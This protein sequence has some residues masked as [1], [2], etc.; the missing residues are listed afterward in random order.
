MPTSH[1]REGKVIG[2]R[3][4]SDTDVGNKCKKMVNGGYGTDRRFFLN[5]LL[6]SDLFFYRKQFRIKFL[7]RLGRDN[8]ILI[9]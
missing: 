2:G 8:L 7:L 9:F 5:N 6:I 1:A 4:A 3:V